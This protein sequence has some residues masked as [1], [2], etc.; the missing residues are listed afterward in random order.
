MGGPARFMASNCCKVLRS[1]VGLGACAMRFLSEG[2]ASFGGCDS[3]LRIGRK[4]QKGQILLFDV[5]WVHHMRL[6]T[7]K[8]WSVKQEPEEN[9]VSDDGDPYTFTA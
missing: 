8:L 3:P 1:R 6:V 7:A 5:V 4:I 9:Q 2:G